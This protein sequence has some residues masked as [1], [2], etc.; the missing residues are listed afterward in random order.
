MRPRLTAPSSSSEPMAAA[1]TPMPA[2]ATDLRSVLRPRA[3]IAT[4]VRA[5][6]IAATG[7]SRSSGT[8]PSERAVART[9]KPTMN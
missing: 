3:A 7:S 8:T 5:L 4:T 6:A 1:V 2:L 9:R